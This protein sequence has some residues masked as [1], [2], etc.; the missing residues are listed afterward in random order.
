MFLREDQCSDCPSLRAGLR[1]IQAKLQKLTKG[2]D[3]TYV[4]FAKEKQQ[5]FK[6]RCRS[7][8]VKESKSLKNLI[9]LE[10]FKDNIP[11]SA[12]VH[13]NLDPQI[14]RQPPLEKLTTIYTV[15]HNLSPP[16][17]REKKV[18]MVETI[19]LSLAG[20]LKYCQSQG[21]TQLALLLKVTLF[22]CRPV[23][24]IAAGQA[25]GA[26]ST[27]CSH[28]LMSSVTGF[29]RVNRLKIVVRPCRQ[30]LMNPLEW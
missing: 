18:H 19:E 21:L 8:D 25:C 2:D 26:I 14:C 23:T 29:Q 22:L 20:T 15:M 9:L 7:R 3:Q 27:S 11:H 30:P 6:R 1:S 24:K 5:C 16:L 10:D 13:Y 4:E 17:V 12:R 28:T